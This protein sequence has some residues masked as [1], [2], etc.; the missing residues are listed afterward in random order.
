MTRR[1]R[2]PDRSGRPGVQPYNFGMAE[3]EKKT[4]FVVIGLTRQG[5]VFR[6][7]DWDERL[8][9][10]MAPFNEHYTP[11]PLG[12]EAVDRSTSG[13]ASPGYEKSSVHANFPR[14]Q[15]LLY[16]P[17]VVPVL[18]SRPGTQEDP[19]IRALRVQARLYA[20]EPMAYNFLRQF[21]ADNDML[22]VEEALP[23]GAAT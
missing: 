16:S 18:V 22:V 1:G 13:T 19:S 14:T 12:E 11:P 10:I 7:S 8:A 23:D 15:G 20:I 5:E 4:S 17:F 2:A 6:P 21:A 3:A 9:G